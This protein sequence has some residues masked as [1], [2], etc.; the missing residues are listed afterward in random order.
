MPDAWSQ[1]FLDA[2]RFDSACPW[3]TGWCFSLSFRLTGRAAHGQ[4]Q[5]HEHQGSGTEQYCRQLPV[6]IDTE[7]GLTGYGEAGATGPMAGARME[8]MKPLLIGKDLLAI[9]VLFE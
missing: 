7:A 9:G 6:R 1:K 2:P 8:T 3:P 4:G 5:D